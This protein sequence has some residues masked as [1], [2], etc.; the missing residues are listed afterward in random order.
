MA[1]RGR[2]SSGVGGSENSGVYWIYQVSLNRVVYVGSAKDIYKRMESHRKALSRGKHTNPHLQSVWNKYG[3]IDFLFL[4]IETCPL[5]EKLDREQFWMDT[6]KPVCNIAISAASPMLGRKFSPESRNLI[7]EER[8]RR[9]NNPEYK[10]KMILQMY[11]RPGTMKG[12]KDSEET[13]AKKRAAA[14]NRAPD[15]EET[16]KKKKEARAKQA[17][18][19]EEAREKMRKTHTG[20]PWSAARRAAY[21]ERYKKK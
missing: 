14:K 18:Y 2:R 21:E 12:K 20:L 15:T 3:P 10:R 6:L 5:S 9:W 16:R 1:Q 13:K 11:G 17:P 4:P 7:S 19:S 8:K